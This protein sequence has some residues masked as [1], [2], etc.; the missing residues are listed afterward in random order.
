MDGQA[1]GNAGEK[2]PIGLS[3]FHDADRAVICHAAVFTFSSHALGFMLWDE[4]DIFVNVK[5]NLCAFRNQ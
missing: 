2:D 1:A 3:S 5:K 4:F